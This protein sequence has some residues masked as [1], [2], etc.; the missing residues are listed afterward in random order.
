MKQPPQSPPDIP[1]RRD[2]SFE[3]GVAGGIMPGVVRLVAE[4]PGPFTFK[5]TNTYLVGSKSLAVIDP[6]PADPRH[7]AAILDAAKGRP[8]THILTTHAHRDHVDGLAELQTKTGARSVGFGRAQLEVPDALKSP[9]GKD[10]VDLDFAPDVAAKDGDVFEGEDWALEALH[11][12][13]HAPD[14][15]CFHLKGRGV[16]FSGD[17]VMSWN[18]TVIAPPE[19]RMAD[20][21]GSLSRLLETNSDLYLPGHGGRLDDARRSVKAFLL[22]RQWREQA[23]LGAIRRKMVTVREMVAMIY[24]DLD[25]KLLTA[26]GLSVMAHVEHLREQDLVSY[27][28]PLGFDTPLRANE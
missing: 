26:A 13:G 8:I 4:N 11:T 18:T 28:D 16:V 24:K 9:S 10:F 23:V 25:E 6:G 2:M 21:L 5:G 7:C 20:Y 27:E 3:Y 17:H 15:I 19:G 22:H 12:P 1:F 14:H